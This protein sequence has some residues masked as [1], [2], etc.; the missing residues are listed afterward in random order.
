[1]S[2]RGGLGMVMVVVVVCRHVHCE[3]LIHV[4]A[5]C[6][7]SPPMRDHLSLD[8]APRCLFQIS[9]LR[10]AGVG[11]LQYVTPPGCTAASQGVGRSNGRPC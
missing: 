8:D 7:H 4:N 10:Y 3:L 5:A 11:A 9:V 6:P 1:M 2:P